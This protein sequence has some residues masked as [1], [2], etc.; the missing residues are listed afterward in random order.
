MGRTRGDE[1]AHYL[2]ILRKK[3]FIQQVLDEIKD[4]SLNYIRSYGRARWIPIREIVNQM[5][6]NPMSIIHNDEAQIL[7]AYGI[8]TKGHI[9]NFISEA[10]RNGIPILCG[11]GSK[12]YKYVDYKSRNISETFMERYRAWADKEEDWYNERRIDLTLI[13][14]VLE[15]LEDY[16]ERQKLKEIKQLYVIKKRRKKLEETK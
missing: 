10:R 11:R 13:D 16:K 14:K 8:G 6:D 4:F 2:R 9:K 3:V 1:E 12:G 15:K 7:L 5:D